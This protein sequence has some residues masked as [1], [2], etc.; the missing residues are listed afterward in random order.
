[1]IDRIRRRVGGEILPSLKRLLASSTTE[2]SA[3]D[4]PDGDRPGSPDM[5]LPEDRVLDLLEEN[6]GQMWQQS[7]VSET[8]YSEPHV[9]RLLCRMEADD[10]VERHWRG[11]EKVVL[12]DG[13]SMDAVGSA[14]AGSA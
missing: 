14:L 3:D 6:G 2:A 5:L 4:S 13:E 10:L 7:I 1:M 12:L 8:E 11:G 9:S